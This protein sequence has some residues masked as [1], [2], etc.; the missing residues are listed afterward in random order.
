MQKVI[1]NQALELALLGHKLKHYEMCDTG[2]LFGDFLLSWLDI[3]ANEVQVNTIAEYRGIVTKHILPYFNQLSKT[4]QGVSAKDIEDYYQ[5]KLRSGMYSNTVTKHHTLLYAAFMYAFR[6]D[7]V[8]SNPMQKVQRPKEYDFHPGFYSPL[9]AQELLIKAQGHRH[10]VAIVIALIL[11][12]R[13]SEV[14]GL[15][16]RSIN[17]REGIIKIENKAIKH[18]GNDIILSKMKTSSSYRILK[19]PTQLTVFFNQLYEHQQKIKKTIAKDKK[20]NF[21]YVCIDDNGNRF[22]LNSVTVAFPRLLKKIGMPPIRFHDLRHS[23]ASILLN[24]GCN[25]KQIQEWLG[26][27]T[28]NTTAK[29][30]AHLDMFN[31]EV[32]AVK[33]DGLLSLDAYSGYIG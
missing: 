31:K 22:T 23:C 30:Y 4:L 6:N 16:W 14:I 19:M 13:R 26:H 25:M 2:L 5:Y 27:S 12:L 18:N 9:E 7:M 20:A 24:N 10:Y 8:I 29:Y 21:D 33:L 17:L 1:E 28:Y 11:G 3:K 15:K 32:V